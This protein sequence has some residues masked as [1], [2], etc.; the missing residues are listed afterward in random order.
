MLNRAEIYAEYAAAL[1]RG[2]DSLSDAE[3]GQALINAI[4]EGQH[5]LTAG[6]PPSDTDNLSHLFSALDTLSDEAIGLSDG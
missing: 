2:V 5:I 3:K 4:L 1:G 6:G